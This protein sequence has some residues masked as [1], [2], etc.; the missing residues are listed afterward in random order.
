MVMG[1]VMGM[2]METPE[3]RAQRQRRRVDCTQEY[4]VLLEEQQVLKKRLS[5]LRATW[6]TRLRPGRDNCMHHAPTRA[7]QLDIM[8]EVTELTNRLQAIAQRLQDIVCEVWLLRTREDAAPPAPPAPPALRIDAQR[9]P[10][11]A[12]E[13]ALQ[14]Q[15]PHRPQ[16]RSARRRGSVEGAPSSPGS[17]TENTASAVLTASVAPKRQDGRASRGASV[18]QNDAMRTTHTGVPGDREGTRPARRHHTRAD[19]V[20]L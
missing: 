6:S 20:R 17:S 15:P 3:Q 10:A 13:P 1:M 2:V 7:D 9:E 8:Q 12:P 5:F 18:R 19:S 4:L 14:A 16:R 11:P